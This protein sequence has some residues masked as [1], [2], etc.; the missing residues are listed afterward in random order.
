[1]K[2]N[3]VDIYKDVGAFR[4]IEDEVDIFLEEDL[5]AC[6]AQVDGE[7]GNP[8]ACRQT[9]Q[10]VLFKGS[11]SNVGETFLLRGKLNA[12]VSLSCVRC[13][14][15][16]PFEEETSIEEEYTE[17]QQPYSSEMQWNTDELNVFSGYT[18]DISDVLRDTLL[19]HLPMRPV[20]KEGCAGLCQTCGKNLNEGACAC[21]KDAVDPRL[22][23]LKSLLEK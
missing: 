16:F 11:I 2:I 13:L 19:V 8:P 18:I 6:G 9:R 17:R 15:A 7:D 3:I 1:M 4:D 20:C 5:S 21:P 10:K 23:K 22:A 12:K 14:S